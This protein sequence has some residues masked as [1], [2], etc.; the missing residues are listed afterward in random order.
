MRSC[1]AAAGMVDSPD[2]ADLIIAIEPECALLSSLASVG[3]ADSK[4]IG[5]VEA[6]SLVLDAGG[7]PTHA[8]L[9][10]GAPVAWGRHRHLPDIALAGGTFDRVHDEVVSS[11][12]CYTFSELSP[13]GACCADSLPQACP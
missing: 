11:A 6:S 12:P 9:A 3:E 13:A 5:A 1:A 10:S 4:A 8:R 2:S 7:E